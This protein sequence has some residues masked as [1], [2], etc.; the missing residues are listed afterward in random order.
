MP[1]E[2]ALSALPARVDYLQRKKSLLLLAC[3]QPSSALQTS[4]AP[5]PGAL[6]AKV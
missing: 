2:A 4:L 3:S 5:Q 1:D 6:A